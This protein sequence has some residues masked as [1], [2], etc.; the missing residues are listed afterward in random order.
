MG[1]KL[2]IQIPCY[3]EEKTLPITAAD[4]P[5]AIEG[6]DCIE[7]VVVD[8]GSC[9]KTVAVA[10]ALKIDHI[11]EF[12]HHKGLSRAYAAG[13]EKSLEVGA[14]IIVNTDADNQYCGNDIARLVK[15]ILSGQADVVIGDRRP[16]KVPH[17]SWFKRL[18]QK[19]GN[20]II[21]K[22]SDLDINDAVS[23]FRAY[24]RDAAIRINIL[25]E[26]SYT[27]ENIFQLTNQKLK[28]ISVPVKTNGV[29]RRSRLFK[30][31][32]YF[33]AQQV[34]TILRV[35]ATYKALKVFTMIGV[36]L[37]IPGL[38]G[39]IRFLYFYFVAGSGGGHIQS[40]IFSMLLMNVGFI[41]FVVGIVADLISTNR[42]LLEKILYRLKKKDFE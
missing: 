27:I 3:N 12:K 9:D 1:M 35:M 11:V 26:F 25:T 34:A 38:L 36:M 29:L 31:I 5:K 33:L 39:F 30:S 42:K 18:L 24:S 23:G 2:V 21:K 37:I 6:I 40:L 19:F 20:R 13:I 10:K 28:I 14:D 41:V 7:T 8:D 22:L 15:P 16:E 4:L 17:F 32:P